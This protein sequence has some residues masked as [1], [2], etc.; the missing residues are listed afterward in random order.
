MA[1]VM[2]GPVARSYAW[3]TQSLLGLAVAAATA[4]AD[5][6]SKFW[7][8]YSFDLPDRFRVAVT[9]FVDFVLTWNTGISYGLFPQNGLVG[10]WALLAFKIVAV[11]LLWIWLARAS[12]RL[13]AISLGLIVGGAVGNAIDRLHWPGVMDFVLFHFE[14]ESFSFRW[15][16]FNLADLAIVAGVAGLLYDSLRE[17]RAA[18]AP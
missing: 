11:V 10:A 16:V 9:P 17:G 7:L 8:L 12:S 6:G 3:G 4:L 5:Q 2:H 15:Y 14:T 1:D 13:T 18:K